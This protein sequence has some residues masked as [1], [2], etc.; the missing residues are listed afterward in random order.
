VTD[1]QLQRL[2]AL[3]EEERILALA[4]QVD[5]RPHL[6]MLPYVVTADFDAVI[7]HASA[8]AKHTR[9]LVNGAP[10]SMV[11]HRP[12]RPDADPLQLARVSVDAVVEGLEKD[13]PAYVH[14]MQCYVARFPTSE[15]TFTMPDFNLYRLNF[16]SGRWVGGFGDA[17]RLSGPTFRRMAAQTSGGETPG[18]ASH[19]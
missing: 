5:G 9:G 6:G 13:T 2:R 11:I 7:V 17:L 1:D 18:D 3:L 15:A 14:A 12:D 19:E 16:V 4:V 8:L 10:V